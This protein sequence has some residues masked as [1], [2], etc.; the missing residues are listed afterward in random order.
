MKEIS[1]EFKES[2]GRVKIGGAFRSNDGLV[3]GIGS[4]GEEF[5]RIYEDIAYNETQRTG[6][7]VAKL[8]S[9]GVKA[10]HPDDGWHNREEFHFGF[11]YPHFDDGV[12]VGDMVALGGHSKFVVVCVSKVSGLFSKRY[13]YKSNIY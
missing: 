8:R 13:H 12:K 1:N 4:G 2:A 10:S 3:E 6:A 7:W 11:A 9:L 5:V